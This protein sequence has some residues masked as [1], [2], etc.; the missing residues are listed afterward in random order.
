MAFGVVED[1]PGLTVLSGFR[2]VVDDAFTAYG[3]DCGGQI[4]DF[5]EEDGFIRGGIIFGTFPF[6]AEE[7]VAC[8][9]LGVVAGGFIG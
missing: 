3:I 7:G 1:G 5:K 9:E 2:F 4:G 8:G 6:E